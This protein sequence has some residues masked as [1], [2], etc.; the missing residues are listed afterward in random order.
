MREREGGASRTLRERIEHEVV[1][2]LRRLASTGWWAT[3]LIWASH[4][5][6]V[7]LLLCAML[8]TGIIPAGTA[9]AMRGLINAVVEVVGSEGGSMAAITPWLLLGVTLAISGVLSELAHRYLI[10]RLRDDLDLT[11]TA[12]ILS[13]ASRLDVA[14]FETPELQDSF[15]RAQQNIASHFTRLLTG[16]SNSASQ[17]I[18]AISLAAILFVVE[19][20]AALI[21]VPL[22]LPH[23]AFRWR[24]SRQYYRVEHRRTARVR[25]TRYFVS[26]LTDRNMV[27]EVK[28]LGLGPLMIGR[29]REL[30]EEFRGQNRRNYMHRFTVDAG[31]AVVGMAV[32]YALLVRV[33]RRV[34]EGGLTVGDVV[35]FVAAAG[36]LRATLENMVGTVSA[37]QEVSLYIGDL[38]EFLRVQPQVARGGTASA[39]SLRGEIEFRNVT[40]TYPGGQAPAVSDVTFHIRPGETVALVGRNGAGKTTLVKLLARFYDPDEGTILIDGKDIRHVPLDH[41]HGNIGLVSQNYIRYE[42]TAAENLAY[43]DWQRLLGD[44]AA[45]EHLAVDAGVDR[46]IESFPRGYETLLGRS[47]GQYEPSGGEW[48]QIAIARA[49]ARNPSLVILDEPTS[50]LDAE[51]EYQVF[52]RLRALAHGR[53]TLLVS[54]R[55][56]TVALADHILV[57]DRGRLVERGSHG[58]LLALDGR[59]ATLFKLQRRQMDGSRGRRVGS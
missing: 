5:R 30:M 4:A 48:Q 39:A 58:E 38:R 40:F 43:G 35:V 36:R 15:H 25:W 3:R 47:F 53:T 1:A 26:L 29:F 44:R 10:G 24:L 11:V 42:A 56:S 27:G 23:L 9:L 16:L 18:Q 45:I 19:P 12:R 22:A 41:L 31:A 21:L 52:T 8:V 54:H 57:L 20:I 50:N 32:V 28:L 33:V 13:H 2:P 14:F 59:Y 46:L 37:V 55:F 7:V 17:V 34:L 49:L 6:L 51:A